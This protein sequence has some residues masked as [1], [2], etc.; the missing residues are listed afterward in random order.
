MSD[1]E[2][3][4]VIAAVMADRTEEMEK[5]LGMYQDMGSFSRLELLLPGDQVITETGA[6]VDAAGRLSF[7]EEA[8]LGAH[9]SGKEQGLHGEGFGVRHYVPVKCDG[10]TAAMLR[11]AG[12][13]YASLCGN[14]R[15]CRAMQRQ[16]TEDVRTGCTIGIVTSGLALYCQCVQRGAVLRV[17]GCQ[18]TP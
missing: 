9:V 16:G 7:A 2:Q 12:F 17:Y 11:S 5:T 1:R 4:T 18:R 14:P 13:S 6:R 3:L 15:T 8:A 10:K